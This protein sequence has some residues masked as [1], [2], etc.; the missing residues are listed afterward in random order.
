MAEGWSLS[1]PQIPKAFRSLELLPSVHSFPGRSARATKAENQLQREREPERRARD[2][3]TNAAEAGRAG[4]REPS[5]LRGDARTQQKVA[6]AR[7]GP[8]STLR[9]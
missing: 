4:A 6:S 1:S 9:G 2:A 7:T 5:G 3:R 8:I